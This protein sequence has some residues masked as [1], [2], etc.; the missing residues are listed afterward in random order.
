MKKSCIYCK[1]EFEKKDGD[2]PFNVCNNQRCCDLLEKYVLQNKNHDKCS[3]CHKKIDQ[4]Y[5]VIKLIIEDGIPKGSEA[6]CSNCI[7]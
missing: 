3:I 5:V 7:S 6:I 4:Q 2:Y 1:K